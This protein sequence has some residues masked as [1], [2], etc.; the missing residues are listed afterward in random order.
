MVG[1]PLLAGTPLAS[2]LSGG[3]F[4]CPVSVELFRVS[5]RSNLM[6]KAFVE[7]LGRP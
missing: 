1:R 5:L 7:T 2:R 4:K 3:H 6:S